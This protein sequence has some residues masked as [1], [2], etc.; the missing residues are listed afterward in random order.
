MNP[1]IEFLKQTEG[2]V[3]VSQDGVPADILE[4]LKFSRGFDG[5]CLE[6][7][8]FAD[9]DA[10]PNVRKNFFLMASRWHMTDSATPGSW[11]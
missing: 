2:T 6:E 1:L 3:F 7:V 11:M 8:L 10:A 9:R 5:T 4:L